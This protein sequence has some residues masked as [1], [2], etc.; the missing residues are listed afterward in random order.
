MVRRKLKVV[1]AG[2]PGFALPS[3]KLLYDDDRI[4]LLWVYTQPDKPQG[5]GLKQLP[6]PVKEW[7][8][9]NSVT[10]RQ[11]TRLGPV[12]AQLLVDHAVDFVVVVAFGQLVPDAML[13]A[14]SMRCVNLHASLL[15]RW[16]GASPVVSAILAGDELIGV[17]IMQ[18]EASLDAGPVLAQS[19]FRNDQQSADECLTILSEDGAKLLLKVLTAWE[20]HLK[21][22]KVQDISQVTWSGRI[23]KRQAALSWLQSSDQVCRHIRAY[24]SNPVA[25]SWVN[26][27]RVRFFSAVPTAQGAN[28][29]PGTLV[30]T[31]STGLLVACG[32]GAL[33]RVTK[34]QFPSKRMLDFNGNPNMQIPQYLKNIEE[35]C[36]HER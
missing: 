33:L 28:V 8:L 23:E 4:D 24:N 10:C 32:D 5:R 11:P 25:Y 13:K 21:H 14:V 17:S 22:A 30:S 6:S 2:T 26:N 16:R 34:L 3:L 7:C 35:Q 29:P 15:P 36:F 12:D 27:L 31:R 18:L 20:I 19:Y 9:Q 1:F